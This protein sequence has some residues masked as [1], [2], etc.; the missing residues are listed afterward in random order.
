MKVN[1]YNKRN[2]LTD[3]HHAGL[4]NSLILLFEKRLKA[5]VY[6]PVG[7]DW[8]TQGYWKVYDHPET[9]KQYLSLDQRYEPIDGTE[10]LNQVLKGRFGSG[11][12]VYYCKDISTRKL[13]K[14]I[15]LEKF[16]QMHFDIVIA[17]IPEHIKP[18]KELIQ[19]YQPHAKL[20]Y[21]IGNQWNVEPNQVENVMASA[22]VEI[23]SQVNG[24]VYHQEFD[25]DIFSYNPNFSDKNITSLVNCFDSASLFASDWELFKKIEKIMPDYS[26]KVYGGG[27]RDGA[28]HG[29]K[30]VAYAISDSRFIWH[31]K[32]GGD[33]YGHIIH[34]AFAMGRP[35][36]VKM[37]YYKDKLAGKLMVDGE[38]CIAID[39]LN[40]QQIVNKIKSADYKKM[41]QNAYMKFV[42]EVDFDQEEQ[43]IQEFLKLLK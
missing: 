7:V 13:N 28:M 20:I 42:Q 32:R 38:T 24:V 31:V 29:D 10:H 14:A 39:G 27:C 5:L 8:H 23:P 17:S 25:T 35:P 1:S 4:L 6:R 30:E 19:K 2:I 3:F 15:T 34:N 21:Q 37:E 40:P 43:K 16:K 11:D 9:V 26:F 33:G 22:L 41:G 36:I 18:F 12:G